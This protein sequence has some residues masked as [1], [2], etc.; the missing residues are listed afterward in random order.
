MLGIDKCSTFGLKMDVIFN[1]K[2]SL[3]FCTDC[4]MKL[5]LKINGAELPCAGLSFNYLGVELGEKQHKLC[6][7]P[8][9][10]IKK[11][12]NAA[13]SICRNT[14]QHPVSVRIKLIQCKC[15]P[16]LMYD[17]SAWFISNQYKNCF[18]NC[19]QN[20]FRYIF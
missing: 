13:M 12:T 3:Y 5:D 9:K 8:N 15:E 19:V 2:K 20:H 11:F 14:E 16:M 7:I 17:L 4:N 6:F 18:K 10:C 1:F